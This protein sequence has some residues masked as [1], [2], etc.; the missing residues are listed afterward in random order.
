MSS[1][2]LHPFP[3]RMAPDIALK[4]ISRRTGARR[5][6]VLDPMCGSGTVL[7]IASAAGH[8][9][10]GFDVDPLAVLISKV[11]VQPVV[12]EDIVDA[13]E[14]VIYAARRMRTTTAPWTDD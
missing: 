10:V 6:K 14:H 13:A 8:A 2:A 12:S 3:A 1:R 9:A 7:T 5:L 11:A 4:S